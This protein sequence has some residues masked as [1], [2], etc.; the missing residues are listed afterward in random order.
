[1][2]YAADEIQFRHYHGVVSQLVILNPESFS[3]TY[4]LRM[5]HG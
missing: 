3:M 1:M 2:M 4:S 5:D